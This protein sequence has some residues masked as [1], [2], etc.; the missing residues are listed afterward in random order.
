MSATSLACEIIDDP[1]AWTA[2]EGEWREL[3]ATSAAASTLRWEWLNTW[4]AVFGDIYGSAPGGLRVIVVRKEGR[5][6]AALPL[7]LQ[8]A[9]TSL[10]RPR[11]GF[12]GTGEDRNEAVYPEK[13]DVLHEPL[14]QVTRSQVRTELLQAL[15]KLNFHEFDS[16]IASDAS[17]LIELFRA[18]PSASS[19]HV[20][21]KYPAPFADLSGGFESYLEKQSSNARQQFRRMLRAVSKSGATFDVASTSEQAQGFFDELVSLHQERWESSGESGAFSSPRVI[22]FHRRLLEELIPNGKAVIARLG[23]S[24]RSIAIL[25][26]FK[27]GT[28]FEFYQSGVRH[29]EFGEIKSPGITAHLLLMQHVAEHGISTYDF[30]AG[31]STY[32]DKLATSTRHLVRI[33]ILKLTLG[34]VVYMMQE[35]GARL[36][37]RLT[38]SAPRTEQE[39][40]H[41]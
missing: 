22:A 31:A 41:A 36:T 38:R 24:T 15:S 27:E 5:L 33:R 9:R 16:G 21:R 37:R 7:Y 28:S 39:S 18:L 20:E 25:Y 17:L 14:D 34:N 10:S 29:E 19:K 32:K 30:L 4:W 12:M 23:T 13:L 26:G 8:N 11:L 6:I 1:R 2:L 35:I 3:Y 40:S